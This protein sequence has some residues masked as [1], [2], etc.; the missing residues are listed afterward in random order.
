MKKEPL[1]YPGAV[2]PGIISKRDLNNGS[3]IP[4]IGF[5][6]F[7]A[8][9]SPGEV[10]AA[11]QTALGLGYRMLDCAAAYNNE[12][13]I[14]QVIAGAIG[15]GVKRDEL[16]ILGKLQNTMHGFR[17]AAIACKKT[18]SDLKLDRLDA[19]L[20]HWPV[21]NALSPDAAAGI[22]NPNSRPYTHEEF[23]DTWQGMESLV[24]QGLVRSIGVSNVTVAKLRLLLRDAAIA[25]A[26]NEMELHPTFQQEDLFSFSL[27]NGILPIGY[28]PIGSPARPERNKLP[29]DLVDTQDP[30]VARVAQAHQVSPAAVCIKWAVQRGQVPVPFSANPA[31][32]LS[33]LLAVTG[34]PLSGEEM[35]ALKAVDRGCRLSRGQGYLWPGALSF[36]EL[37]DEAPP[38]KTG[39]G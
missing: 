21:P 18:L 14:G 30:I 23:M 13:A 4:C 35:E 38:G 5:G 22:F 32:M 1:Q 29:G 6:T 28:S 39:G 9:Y 16:F 20:M 17:N 33:N 11:V 26:I 36:H 27:Q 3:S 12:D 25:P 8:K 10:A 37:W 15:N 19:Y 34:D 24:R 7:S 2:D 31:N